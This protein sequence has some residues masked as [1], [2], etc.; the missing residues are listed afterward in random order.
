MRGLSWIIVLAGLLTGTVL[1]PDAWAQGEAA[2]PLCPAG[3]DCA[4]VARWGARGLIFLGLIFLAV[5]FVP[6][7]QATGEKKGGVGGIPVVQALQ[8]RIEKELTGWRR[9]QWPVLGV[10]FIALGLA[11]LAGWR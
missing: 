6:P 3:E 8:R 1:V 10:F 4:E 11:T 5:W 2:E 9:Y 7:P